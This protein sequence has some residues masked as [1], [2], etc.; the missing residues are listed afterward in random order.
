M[1]VIDK[2]RSSLSTYA[3]KLVT[4]KIPVDMIGRVIG[5]GGR[6]IKRI[7]EQT[8]SNIEIE[9]D[10]TVYISTFKANG[11]VEAKQ[12]IELITKPVQV[13]KIYEGVVV[14]VKDFGAF[15]EIAPG[16]EGLCH[17]SELADRFIKSVSDVCDIGDKMSFKVIA[18]DEQGRVKLSRK[19]AME[20]EAVSD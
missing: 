1:S 19:A 4:M 15:V 14:S 2:P 20:D 8:E 17:I 13:N 16:L 6:D 5:P 9:D 12:I 18:V 7:Q 10:G 11:H 3:P